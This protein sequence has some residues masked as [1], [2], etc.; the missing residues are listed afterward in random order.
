MRT[1]RKARRKEE[2]DRRKRKKE[3]KRKKKEGSETGLGRKNVTRITQQ[4][5]GGTGVQLKLTDHAS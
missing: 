4:I 5:H 3:R 2:K 1:R